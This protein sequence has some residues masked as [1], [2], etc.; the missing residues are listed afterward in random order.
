MVRISVRRSNE[1]AI[2]SRGSGKDVNLNTLYN[3]LCF[4]GS[5][6][7]ERLF[8]GYKTPVHT[9]QKTHYVFASGPNRLMLCKI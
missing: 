3:V 5:D 7:E 4:H 8:L 6:Y 9:T 1:F 2:L